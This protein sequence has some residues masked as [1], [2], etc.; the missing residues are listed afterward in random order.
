VAF[1]QTF[2]VQEIIVTYQRLTGLHRSNP[3]KLSE[4][5]LFRML[6]FLSLL[7]GLSGFII[8]TS[9]CGSSHAKLRFVQAS[10]DAASVDVLVDGKTV[11][12]GVVFGGVSPASG[13][14]TIADGNHKVEVRTTGITTDLIN[15]TIDFASQKEYTLLAIE[16]TP[17]P[18]DTSLTLA[19]LLKTDDNSAPPS[20]NVKLRFIHTASDP[21]DMQTNPVRVDVYIVAPNTDITN[22][23]P[24]IASLG[25][26]QASTYQ[27]LPAATYEV[28]VTTSGDSAKTRLIDKTYD[29]A[30]GQIRTLVTVD[31]A[32]RGSMS[33]T[34]LVLSDLN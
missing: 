21:V 26:Q 2:D 19:A 20:G 16:L 6:T 7:L 22:V 34:P 5:G 23:S 1:S 30:A 18:P 15:S 24:T 14:L 12:P 3:R 4:H 9:G 8:S 31:V 28:I 33:G 32:G 13:Y 27:T 29:L 25:Y 10:P 11:A 17:V